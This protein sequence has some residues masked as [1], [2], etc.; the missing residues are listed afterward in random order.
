MLFVGARLGG[1][2]GVS[3]GRSDTV[4]VGIGDWEGIV[5]GPSEGWADGSRDQDGIRDGVGDFDGGIVREGDDEGSMGKMS[6]PPISIG[7]SSS[8]V[9]PLSPLS[10]SAVV[11]ARA[12]KSNKS[13]TIMPRTARCFRNPPR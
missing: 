7:V 9:P 3:V 6:S 4:V 10:S 5:E 2:L 11:A 1:V 13:N 12:A 8:V